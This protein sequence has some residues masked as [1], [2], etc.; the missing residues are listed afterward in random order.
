MEESFASSVLASLPIESEAGGKL[1]VDATPFLMRDAINIEALL[2]RQNQGSFKLDPQ[3]SSIYL[4]KTKAFPKNTEVEV[5]LT[6][7]SDTP[8]PLV[9]SVAPDGHA[10]T[11]RLHH[12]FVQP[13][14]DGYK[15]RE[16]DPR[17]G[18]DGLCSRTIRRRI[19]PRR[20][21]IGCGV[22]AWR[23]KILRRKISEPKQP[24]VYYLDAGIPE[25]IRSS[26]RD[27]ILWWNEAFEAAG[28]QERH[29]GERSDAGHGSDGY[30]LQLRVLGESRRARF[31]GRRKLSGSANRRNSGGAGTHGFGAHPDHQQL[32]ESYMEPALDDEAFAR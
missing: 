8:G 6:Y 3:R 20:I 2:R 31:L 11:I 18:A 19:R 25:P 12:S 23:R 21:R 30:P 26:M 29:G 32:L 10:L 9:N 28:L 22:S 24:L 17:I 14:D 7:A 4:P 1:V 27:G 16:G 13:P 15:P 5:T